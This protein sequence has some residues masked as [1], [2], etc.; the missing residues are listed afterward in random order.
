MSLMQIG[1]MKTIF[2]AFYFIFNFRGVST[3]KCNRIRFVLSSSNTY[4]KLLD[5]VYVRTNRS[6][7]GR[8]VFENEKG[9]VYFWYTLSKQWYFSKG[10]PDNIEYKHFTGLYA[11]TSSSLNYGAK[12][13]EIKHCERFI[14]SYFCSKLQHIDR[15]AQIKCVGNMVEC[16]Y[17][18]LLWNS[19]DHKS[20]TQLRK[21]FIKKFQG[22]YYSSDRT[23]VLKKS[24]SHWYMWDSSPYSGFRYKVYSNVLKPELITENWENDISVTLQCVGDEESQCY[25]PSPP[26]QNSGVCHRNDEGQSWC[27]CK[28]DFFGS[29]CNQT[30]ITTKRTTISTKSTQSNYHQRTFSHYQ[31]QP[32]EETLDNNKGKKPLLVFVVLIP[33]VILPCLH[34]RIL[35]YLT[36][37]RPNSMRVLSMHA[38]GGKR[39]I[40]FFR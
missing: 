20:R 6:Q 23:S 40:Y 36:K 34:L 22:D 10:S 25:P 30:K 4:G 8:S 18:S 1:C 2:F 39:K 24:G 33:L 11:V 37:K 14:D 3:F 35:Y 26:C 21:I 27:L 5:D 38:Y 16:Q 15:N 29:H 12:G 31:P 13:V 17:R 28:N 7:H 19:Y 32:I 9:G